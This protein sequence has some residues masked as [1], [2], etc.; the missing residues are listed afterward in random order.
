MT[1]RTRFVVYLA[2]LHALFVGLAA[3]LLW[4]WPY[5]LIP[6]EIAFVVSLAV[7][8]SLSRRLLASVRFVNDGLQ[9]IR[10]Q[11]FTS[12]LIEVG[13]P[14][15][16]ALVQVYNTMVDHLREERTRLQ[17]QQHFLEQIVRVSPTGILVL[18]FERT[19]V[20]ANPAAVRLL[21][22][23]AGALLGRA[24]ENVGSSL[25]LAL[26]TLAP[27]EGIVVGLA[28]AR[29]VKC[30]HGRFMDRGF[31][32]SFFLLEELTEELRRYERSAYE[33]LIRVMSHEVNNSVAASNSLLQSCLTYG[34][35]LTGE[36]RAD[37]ERALGI[38]ITRTTEL[39]RFMRQ[40]ADVFRLPPPVKA[41]CDL[42]EL[43][44]GLVRLVADKP[45][46]AG[47]VWQWDLP[48][49]PVLVA[50]DRAQMEQAL[51]NVLLNAVDAAGPFGTI[52]I[53]LT[54]VAARATLVIEDSGPELSPEAQANLFTPFF[55]TKPNGQGI[56]LTVVQEILTAHGFAFS[57]DH[58]PGGPTRFRI[59]L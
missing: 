50:L 22:V 47:I 44:R 41:P 33:K 12:R 23:P 42:V 39:N 30:H 48:D 38:V 25:A 43:L 53:R 2:V 9:L 24:L 36:T 59:V 26:Q 13:Q 56:G 10:D 7:G 58:P 55:S 32:R 28:G 17:E 31:A 5:A 14:E 46:A 8:I 40:F 15:V 49:R 4:R 19:I 34:A 37:F 16:D 35:A 51:L 20:Q 11:E 1:I 57:L 3:A 18:D 6:L 27:G 52:T 29:R 54:Q 45:Q 21:D